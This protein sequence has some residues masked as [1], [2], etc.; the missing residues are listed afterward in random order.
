MIE[1]T[2]AP[3]LSAYNR[4]M[5]QHLD[6]IFFDKFVN[7]IVLNF[8]LQGGEKNVPPLQGTVGGRLAGRH[9]WHPLE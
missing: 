4:Q 8:Y 2:Q 5:K 7:E 6:I 1:L 9:L 3:G